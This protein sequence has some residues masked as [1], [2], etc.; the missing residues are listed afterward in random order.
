[1]ESNAL[2]A[3]N[4]QVESFR[5]LMKSVCT[6]IPGYVSALLDNGKNQRVQV[7]IGVQRVDINGA[8]FNPPP[9]ID[10]PVLFPGGD[11]VIEYEIA[12]GCEGMIFFSQRCVDGWKNTGG[13]A[14]NPLGRFHHMQDAF[15]VPGFRSLAGVITDFQNNGIRIRDKTGTRNI[16]IKNDG[17]IVVK[18]GAAITTYGVDN[19]VTT[20]NGAGAMA[21]LENGNVVINGVVITPAGRLSY[22]AGGGM[23]GSNGIAFET[24]RHNENGTITGVPIA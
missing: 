1:M 11:Y 16:W 6:C 21:L 5:E 20:T 3:T 7:Q 9:I 15:F 14:A 2:N 22:P 4:L 17:S 24:H 8:V 18:N 10:V 23:T 19:S 13:I 12:Q